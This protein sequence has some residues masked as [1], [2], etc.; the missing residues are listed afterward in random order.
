WPPTPTSGFA[1]IEKFLRAYCC[2]PLPGLP[3]KGEGSSTMYPPL[4]A[5]GGNFGNPFPSPLAGEG[6]GVRPQK[7]HIV[8]L[9]PTLP[10]QGGGGS[11]DVFPSPRSRGEFRQS[12]PLSPRGRG[13]RGEG[14]KASH[15][16]PLPDPPPSRGREVRRCIPLSPLKGGISAIHSPLPSRERGRG[17]GDLL[18]GADHV[19]DGS[20]HIVIRQ[21]GA[22]ALGR[23]QTVFAKKSLQGVLVEGV[24]ALRDAR[25]PCLLVAELGRARD[26]A[27][28]AG[29]ADGVVGVLALVARRQGR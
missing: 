13:G 11:D 19:I 6:E 10:P 25:R 20:L 1:D 23:H 17:E 29:E 14:A 7:H 9:S 2:H 22:A 15:C 26:A 4:P 27:G 16:H 21:I 28:V 8:T 12:I 5:Q 3:L 18:R 24:P